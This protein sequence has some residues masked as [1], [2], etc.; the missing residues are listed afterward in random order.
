M[1]AAKT[2]L[3]LQN[4]PSAFFM[5]FVRRIYQISGEKSV[6]ENKKLLIFNQEDIFLFFWGLFLKG[7][8]VRRDHS[9]GFSMH[10]SRQERAKEILLLRIA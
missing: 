5:A 4:E 6:D 7:L 10:H 8:I 3:Y 1:P 2:R 9:F